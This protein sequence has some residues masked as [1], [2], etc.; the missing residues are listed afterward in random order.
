LTIGRASALPRALVVEAKAIAA[1]GV[2]LPFAQTL[3]SA[4]VEL[5]LR[6]TRLSVGLGARHRAASLRVGRDGR[7]GH[8]EC[9]HERED[10]Q[11]AG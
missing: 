11:T 5:R 9:G 1:A 4:V 7:G 3:A 2:G 6:F 8:R 10:G